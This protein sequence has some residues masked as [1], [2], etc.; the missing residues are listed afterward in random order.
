MMKILPLPNF[1]S[2]DPDR[3][4]VGLTKYCTT[5]P[6]IGHNTQLRLNHVVGGVLPLEHRELLRTLN[7]ILLANENQE[8]GGGNDDN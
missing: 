6:Q 3:P 5:K 1:G 4:S 7:P 2:I 8:N